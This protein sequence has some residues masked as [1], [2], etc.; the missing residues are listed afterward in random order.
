MKLFTTIE[1]PISG[2]VT[3]ITVENEAL[4]QLDEVLFV[5]EPD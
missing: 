3:R 4:V 1:A 2:R 5:I